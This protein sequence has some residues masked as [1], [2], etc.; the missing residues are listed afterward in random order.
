MFQSIVKPGFLGNHYKFIYNDFITL[1]FHLFR[2][3]LCSLSRRMNQVQRSQSTSTKAD[4]VTSEQF[5]YRSVRYLLRK[6]EIRRA[7]N[8]TF[9]FY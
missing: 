6:K 9:E 3:R 7:G 4:L 8:F 2:D 1:Y 5:S